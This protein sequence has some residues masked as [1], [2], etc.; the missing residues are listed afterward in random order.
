MVHPMTLPEEQQAAALRRLTDA[1]ERER[2]AAADVRAAAIEAKAAGVSISRLSALANV[3]RDKVYGWL[4][5]A[6]DDPAPDE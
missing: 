2:Q 1:L 6:P 5:K 4:R 3:S